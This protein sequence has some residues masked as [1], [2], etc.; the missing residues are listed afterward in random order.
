MSNSNNILVSESPVAQLSAAGTKLLSQWLADHG[1]GRMPHALLLVGTLSLTEQLVNQFKEQLGLGPT[2]YWS[3]TSQ[4][5]IKIEDIRQLRRFIQ[6]RQSGRK[7]RLLFLAPADGLTAEAGN[8]LLKTLEEPPPGTHLFLATNKPDAVLATI[9][10]RCQ[11][12]QLFVDQSDQGSTEIEGF[13]DVKSLSD[14][15]RQSKELAS[16]SEPLEHYFDNWLSQL[17]EQ[18]PDRRAAALSQTVLKYRQLCQF[19]P[20]RRLLLDNFILDLYNQNHD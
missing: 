1:E 18:L 8:A 2:D 10:S 19:N 17:N 20:N 5:T 12:Q 14:S 11:Q 7:G 4:T 16:Q 9:R 3:I 15:F 13:I 6:L